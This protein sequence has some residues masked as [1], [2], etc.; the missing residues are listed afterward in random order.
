MKKGFLFGI[1]FALFLFVGSAYADSCDML[2]MFDD[3]YV[4]VGAIDMQ[5]MP[6]REIYGTLMSFFM[7]DPEAHKVLVDLEKSGLTSKS[8]RRI[9]VGIP[10]DVERA[11]FLMIWETMSSIKP[12]VPVLEKYAASF[13]KKK[14]GNHDYYCKKDGNQCLLMLDE[15]LVLASQA[16]MNSFILMLDNS[17]RTNK[18]NVKL[19]EIAQT[20]D[21]KKDAWLVFWLDEVQRGRIGQGDPL[22]DMS[23]EGK[24]TLRLGSIQSGNVSL[25][26]SK[27]MHA[28][29]AIQML[30]PAHAK[31]FS[32]I[33]TTLLERARNDE[34][35][36]TLGLVDVMNGI[37]VGARKNEFVVTVAY[38]QKTFS[39]LISVVSDLVKMTARDGLENTTAKKIQS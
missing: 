17:G 30:E 21:Q 1:I 9:V 39:Q 3:T 26:F 34:D 32:D 25:D 5:K 16:K 24:G 36:K 10:A 38:S 2:D 28:D 35:V 37:Q 33:L 14:L 13:E 4:G 22:V 12:Y 8:V 15:S 18:K 11:E 19:K 27:G 23:A 31:Y 29:I 7:T 20:T 6:D